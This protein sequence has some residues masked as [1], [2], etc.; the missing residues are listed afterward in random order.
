MLTYLYWFEGESDCQPIS[1]SLPDIA[2]AKSEAART[3]GL[4]LCDAAKEPWN[5]TDWGITVTDEV[6]RILFS[7]SISTK[8]ALAIGSADRKH[9][10]DVHGL[11]CAG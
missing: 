2:A 11:D 1:R 10:S 6:G 4:M 9:F 5:D 3:L 8:G 7:L